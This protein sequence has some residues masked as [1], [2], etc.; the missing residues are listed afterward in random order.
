MLLALVGL[1]VAGAFLL[2]KRGGRLDAMRA[3]AAV[4]QALHLSPAC[5]RAATDAAPVR[6]QGFAGNLTLGLVLHRPER[7]S[8]ATWTM[9]TP[10]LPTLPSASDRHAARFY[11][12][13]CMLPAAL[14]RL[15]IC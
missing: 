8:T 2:G 4:R 15:N 7:L 11:C 12:P 9:R 3:D 10:M 1:V 6:H 14:L 5:C 13:I